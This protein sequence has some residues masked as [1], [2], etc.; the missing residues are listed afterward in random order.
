M[1]TRRVRRVGALASL[2]GAALMGLVLACSPPG[3]SGDETSGQLIPLP[4]DGT[5]GRLT[6]VPIAAQ[7]LSQHY[8]EVVFDQAVGTEVEDPSLYAIRG[9]GGISLAVTEVLRRQSDTTRVLLVTDAQAEVQYE[10]TVNTGEPIAK[11]IR[12]AASQLPTILFQGSSANEPYVSSAIALD[13]TTVLVTYSSNMDENIAERA[14]YEIANPDLKITAVSIVNPKGRT[15]VLLTTEAQG[16]IDYALRV[17]NVT[18]NNGSQLIDP[19]RCTVTFNGIAPAEPPK[20]TKAVA[21]SATTVL[22]SFNKQLADDAADPTHFQIYLAESTWPE[23][24]ITSARM[25]LYSTQVELTTLPMTAG[26]TYQVWAKYIVDRGGNFILTYEEYGG[27]CAC[28]TVVTFAGSPETEGPADANALP[29][30]VGAASLSN[31]SVVVTFNKPMGESAVDPSGYVIV[32]ENVNPE[33]G[34]LIIL[35]A[36]WADGPSRKSVRLITSSQNEVTYR[37]TAVNV[38][39]LS[40]NGMAPQ[41]LL[42]DPTSATFAGTPPSGDDEGGAGDLIDS[43]GDGLMDNQELRGYVVAVQLT[44]G[45]TIER[46]VTS[47]PLVAD[48]DTDGLT[49]GD[50]YSLGTDPRAV[51]TDGDLISDAEEFNVWFT[52]P[53][54]QDTDGDE[55]V[56]WLEA[57]FYKS[58]PLLADTDG[59]GLDD[60]RELVELNRDPRVADL[61]TPRIK[62]GDVR[63]QL[64]ERFTYNDE[65]GQ[66][67][68]V[69]KNSQTTLQQAKDQK[70][71]TSESEVN[72]SEWEIAGKFGAELEIS[73]DPS[74]TLSAEV[75][76]KYAQSNEHTSQFSLEST[77]HAEETFEQSLNKGQTLTNSTSVQ[78]ELAGASL[79]AA[80]TI[81]NAGDIAFTI[82]NLSLTMLEQDRRDRERFLP[83]ASLMPATGQET[84]FNLGPLLPERG[85]VIFSNVEVYPNL[86]QDLMKDPRGLITKVAN[87]DIVDEFG[88]N[89]AF[90]SQE[91]NDKTAGIVIDYGDGTAEKYRVA[92]AGGLDLA[93]YFPKQCSADSPDFGKECSCND[94]C[95]GPNDLGTCGPA[96]L[97]GFDDEGRPVGLPLD[98]ILQDILK[99]KKNSTDPDAIVAGPDQIAQTAAQGDDVQ[100]VPVGTRGLEERTIVVGAGQNG[101]L[102]TAPL[103]DDQATVTAGYETRRF[104]SV[105]SGNARADCTED[106]NCSEGGFC[107]PETLVRI[108]NSRNRDITNATSGEDFRFWV[109]L[110]PNQIPLGGDFGSIVLKPRDVL[111]LAYVQDLDEDG[112]YARQ[113][114]MYGSSDK[115]INTDGG[116]QTPEII[117]AGSNGTVDTVALGDDL[118]IVDLGTTGLDPRR[119]IISAGANGRIDSVLGDSDGDAVSEGG[120]DVDGVE[121]S[122]AVYEPGG[123][124]EPLDGGNGTAQTLAV[125]DDVQA[126]PLGAPV[127]PGEVIILPGPNGVLDT[128]PA[129]DDQGPGNG[130]PQ[131]NG[132]VSTAAQ[133]DDIQV[134]PVGDPVQ[135]GMAVVLAGPNGVID[136][137]PAG[138]EYLGTIKEDLD[139]YAEVRVGWQCPIAGQDIVN[140]YPDPRRADSDG[141]GL[142][143]DVEKGYRTDP[144]ARDTDG[145]MVI[146]TVEING[147]RIGI[148]IT[149]GPNGTV[150]T[151]AEF[152]DIQVIRQSTTSVPSNTLVI[153]P[154]PNGVLDTALAGDDTS[155]P[156]TVVISNPLDPDTDGDNLVDG[157]ERAFGSNPLDPLDGDTIRDVDEDGLTDREELLGYDI[158][159]MIPDPSSPN[160]SIPFHGHVTTDPTRGDTDGD[161]LP[162]LLESILRTDPR[163]NDSDKDG[164]KDFDELANLEDFLDLNDEFHGFSLSPSG[165]KAVGT[166]PTDADS[167][168]DGLTDGFEVNEGWRVILAG[169]S[170]IR[171]VFPSP[172]MRDTD[173]D[174]LSDRPEFVKKTDPTNPDTDNDGRR[175]GIEDP[176]TDPLVPDA[177]ISVNFADLRMQAGSAAEDGDNKLAEWSWNFRIRGPG[178]KLT[179]VQNAPSCSHNLPGN[180]FVRVN[181]SSAKFRMVPGDV[182]FIEGEVLESDDCSKSL[183]GDGQFCLV[184]SDDASKCPQCLSGSFVMRFSKAVGFEDLQVSQGGG[185][186]VRFIAETLEM[187]TLI[188]ELDQFDEDAP[189]TGKIDIRIL[190][191]SEDPDLDGDGIL[192][193]QDSDVDGDGL[194]NGD[195]MGYAA[196]PDIDDD[197]LLNG[198]DEDIDSDGFLNHQDSDMD[199]DGK[200]NADDPDIDGDGKA[201]GVDPDVDADFIPNGADDNVDG[202]PLL[203]GDDPDVDG[204]GLANGNTT[205]GSAVDPDIDGD[206]LLNGVDD[207]IDGDGLLNRIEAG[208]ETSNP[209]ADMDGDGVLNSVDPDM[210]NDGIANGGGDP[211]IDADGLLNAPD[212]DMDGDGLADD[213]A[214]ELDMDGDGLADDAAD[215]LDID[216]DGLADDAADELDIDGDE[217][218]DD[219]D[220]EL[221]ID[222]DGL[223]DDDAG[224]LDIDGDGRAD[225]AAGELDID[226]DGLADDDDDELDIDGDGLADDAAGELDIDGDGLA[227]DAA[228]ELDID[229]DGLADDA[230]ELDIDGD[231]R[232]DDAADELDIDGDGLA[233]DAADELDIDGDGLADDA[234]GELDIDGDGLADDAGG[235]LDI[236]GDGLADD[237]D[238][239]LDI[240]GD[241]LADTDPNELDIDGDGLTDIDPSELDI[242]G[243]GLANVNDGDMD[244]DGVINTD[245]TDSPGGHDNDLDNDGVLND[246][247]TDVDGDGLSN[248]DAL[249]LDIDGDGLL[250]TDPLEFDI[251]GDGVPNGVDSTPNGV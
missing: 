231:G 94:D 43:D 172:L 210:D 17:T 83:V 193:G 106:S 127:G 56:D 128:T 137:T 180:T 227:D 89:F 212:P 142:L 250:D 147:Y 161:G 226:G 34:T 207:D 98:F 171:Q 160:S 199:G 78:R 110:T 204:D 197:S 134:I 178:S 176:P 124:R 112:L 63:L 21:T 79:S 50:E 51:D 31:T 219:D 129:G 54:N 225:D 216:G 201:N 196:D 159:F 153:L 87:F 113:E 245:D 104:C 40:G 130:N 138:D 211:D 19:T 202:D 243:D 33:V 224:E 102:D 132:V 26:K 217:L 68:S 96:Y 149:P 69:Q 101:V 8:V 233:D 27:Q 23:L 120:D 16:N 145:D 118:Q 158:D 182:I 155:T 148:G 215:E 162:D 60:S 38:R 57:R 191:D 240:D 136:A 198:E 44:S 42:V 29:R 91:A 139:D 37:V 4:F 228:G 15:M 229:G 81:E 236:D 135:P 126:V 150:D 100:V 239:E 192:N 59:D 179:V 242:D 67:V 1:M 188:T 86:V 164:L 175:D 93:G 77:V 62:I 52:E 247:D 186:Q 251:D 184:S 143:D 141:D 177:L 80:V 200:A 12:A 36:D 71:A 170:N 103:G 24:S 85:P 55:L 248:G 195:A 144:K 2:S 6:A 152:D 73:K 105:T 13:E 74:L 116:N 66:E 205:N 206:G 30:V 131:G 75:S 213:A 223:A 92:V 241:G 53:T 5:S 133:F 246:V 61:P 249:E 146:D 109:A 214:D 82:E 10:L 166:D 208:S 190:V 167:D 123:I 48:T 173:A 72:K 169:D 230:D 183:P 185:S 84:V 11:W 221:D 49:D 76:G 151:R 209:D 114:Y 46:Q 41:Q 174:G 163:S 244:G 122:E 121:M 32:Q 58:S 232:A 222:G 20:I 88:R 238:D 22:I 28:Y 111:L 95:I 220:D 189:P 237:D 25:T 14:Y 9:P 154:G 18:A 165:S 47:N 125:E 119:P 90:A 218:A 108:G 3:Q 35:S 187:E 65:R 235:E 140:V 97:G 157:L 64:D 156:G 7:A 70:F 45:E 234:A 203:N 99:L 117:Y 115:D 107:G 39:D 194:A 168:D 181:A